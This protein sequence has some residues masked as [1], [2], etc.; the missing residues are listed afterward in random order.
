MSYTKSEKKVAKELF[1][2]ARQRDYEHLQTNIKQYKCDTPQN[3]WDLREFLNKKAKEFD[4]KYDYRYSVL[5]EVFIGF[6]L[7]K[8][9]HIDEMKDFSKERQGY[10]LS[11][12]QNY[13]NS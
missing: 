9:L 10:F 12:T 13:I 11:R 6:I 8:L 4:N 7:E 1:E 5:D 3:I 2:L